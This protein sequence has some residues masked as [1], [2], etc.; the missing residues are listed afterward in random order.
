MTRRP[1]WKRRSSRFQ[2]PA[3]VITTAFAAAIATGAALLSLPA[4]TQSGQRAT[5]LD[6]LFTATSAVCVTGL[7]TVDTGSYWS[8]FGQVVILLLIQVGGLGIMTLATLFTV[9]LSRR[10][11]LRA[12]FLAQAET[13]SL[14]LTD[15]R[16]V[17][18]RIVLF[19]LVSEA[20]V[21][22][23]L[24]LRFATAY[25]EPLGAAVYDGVF[26]AVSA[27]NNAGFSTNADSLV[28]Y[29]T[30]PWITLTI[31]AAVILGG[32]G[33]P[34]VFELVR[35]WRPAQWS[36]LTRLTVTL[37]V[38]LLVLG[39]LV[40]TLAEFT[41]PRTLGPLSGPEKLLAGFFASA[42]TRTA[43]FNSLDIGA[44]RPESLLASD[45]LMFIGGGSAGTAGGIKVTTFGLLAFVL[46]SEMR[47]ETHVNVGRR[48][49]PASN[50]R[51]ALAV[52][53]LGVGAVVTATFMLVA[54]T[55][56]EL[57]QILFE[58]VSAFA[59]VGLSTGIT[60]SLPPQADLLLIVLMFAGRI[61]PLTLASALALRE[62]TRRFELPEER[63]IVG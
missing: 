1:A 33:F 63:T 9:L 36:V 19:S 22:V 3:Q 42:M 56:Y 20:V 60:G 62:R 14:N 38:T 49:I 44:M 2:H 13:K 12:R 37:T 53:L 26:H 41:N 28:G 5:L 34:V 45:V 24:T 25:H 30:D 21:A 48:R 59:T 8:G 31:A 15:V 17:V 6:A 40:L 46:W 50:Q 35:C 43:G 4:A 7:V 55:S 47:G 57:E 52:A 11:G 18:R 32:L 51:Q 58:A 10:L 27:F 29:V 39:T 23:A 16:G 54:I 61:G